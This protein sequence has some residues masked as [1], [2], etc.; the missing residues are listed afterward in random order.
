MKTFRVTVEIGADKKGRIIT[1]FYPGKNPWNYGAGGFV[2][3]K[4]TFDITIVQADSPYAQ[5]FE[6]VV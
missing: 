4:A 3:D 5:G 6:M 1:P 2:G